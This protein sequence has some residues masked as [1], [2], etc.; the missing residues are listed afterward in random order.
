MTTG[1]IREIDSASVDADGM[2]S[3]TMRIL[4]CFTA[5]EPELSASRLG[6]LTGLSSS[7]LHRILAQMLDLGLLSR[8]P[9]RRYAVGVR[10]WELGELS[11]L[12]LRL[13]E[14]ALPYMTRLYEATGENVHLAVL[15]A[16]APERATALYV[17]RLT[18][19]GS[20]PTLSRM[21]GRQPLHTT[22]VGKAL[23]AMQSGDWIDRFLAQPLERETMYS[24]TEPDAI[25]ME[26]DRARARGY[27][28]TREEM[29][30]G[31]VSV[32]APVGSIAGLP[33]AALGVVTRIDGAD[34]R[35]LGALVTQTAA[36]LGRALRAL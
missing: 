35:R 21:G 19:R 25:R 8:T 9:G 18:G 22:G 13:R 28:T 36:D 14:T 32:A 29:T 5:D 15:D 2:L 26:I 33:P 23:L 16:P 7:T 20:I 17:G 6:A 3:R 34:T 10:L 27:A 30:L 31:N 24:I 12:A 11:P 4:G 1:T